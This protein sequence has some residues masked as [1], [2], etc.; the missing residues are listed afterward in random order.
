VTAAQAA[1]VPAAGRKSIWQIVNHVMFWRNY[2]LDRAAGQTL[3]EQE[4]A[5]RNWEAPSRADEA[6]WAETRKK[7][8]ASHDRISQAIA[9]GDGPMDKLRYL[10]PHDSYHLGQIM[11]LRAMQDL[12]VIE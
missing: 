2:I 11:Y 4:I 1:Y 10:L 9:K 3:S 8:K 6:S 12:P 7:L 5:K